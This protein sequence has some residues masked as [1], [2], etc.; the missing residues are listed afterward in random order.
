MTRRNCGSTS[1]TTALVVCG[2]LAGIAF[3]AFS[4]GAKRAGASTTVRVGEVVGVQQVKI[5]DN[6]VAKGA[7]VGGAIG[8]AFGS[9][10]SGKS[11]R[12]RA[13]VGIAAG[14]LAGAAK[15]NPTGMQ[16]SVRT[17]DDVTIQVVTDQRHLRMGDCVA[18]EETG[19]RANLR[20]L[21]QTACQAESQA[22]LADPEIQ[23]EMQEEAL[24]CIEAKYQLLAA[25]TDAQV[26]FALRKVAILCDD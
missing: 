6:S 23:Q 17:G 3:P 25:E 10:K 18:V 4:Q 22:V 8:L 11:T 26:D 1:W 5:K 19:G 24:E 21:A 12:K 7:L 15:P 2:M 16:Y 9:G 13:A 20:R 14:A